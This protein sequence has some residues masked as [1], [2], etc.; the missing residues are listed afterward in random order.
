MK[1]YD[2]VIMDIGIDKTNREMI[3]DGLTRVL[4]DNYILFLKTRN[5]H[6]NVTG[7]NFSQL[8]ALFQSVYESLDEAGDEIAERIRALGYKAPGSYIEFVTVSVLREEIGE[9]DSTEML[10]Q[11]VLDVEHLV[12]RTDEVKEVSLMGKDD[13][14]ADLLIGQ[15]RSLEKFAWMLRSHLER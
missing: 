4:A 8:H 15:L 2:E 14:T 5:Y 1:K 12:R 13:V 11:L 3:A 9:P 10:Q 6:W 7:P